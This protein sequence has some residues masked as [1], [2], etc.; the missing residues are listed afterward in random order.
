MRSLLGPYGLTLKSPPGCGDGVVMVSCAS[1]ID[2]E[3]VPDSG[4]LKC[5]LAREGIARV[6]AEA[7]QETALE[8][9][10]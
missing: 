7:Y 3:V 6:C 4:K 2:A 8:T 10:L 5:W 1:W 9:D